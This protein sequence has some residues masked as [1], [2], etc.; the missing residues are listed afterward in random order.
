MLLSLL[1]IFVISV[2]ASSLIGHGIHW[3]LHQ[4]WMGP[5]WRGHMQHHLELYPP[6]DLTSP[7]YRT[8]SWFNSGTFLFTPPLLLI[9]VVLGSIAL[10]IG[11]SLW[12]VAAAAVG[13]AGFGVVNDI[14]HDNLH[15]ECSWMSRFGWYEPLQRFHFVH[16][17]HMRR[18]YGVVTAAWDK[19]FGSFKDSS[20]VKNVRTNV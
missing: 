16:H 3:A 19:L 11:V 6:A 12:F 14:V 7:R 8:A 9:V 4:R 17:K 10:F 2:F 18:N 15:I 5:A 13:L 20:A 1:I